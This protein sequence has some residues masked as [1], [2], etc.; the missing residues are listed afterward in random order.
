MNQLEVYICPLPFKPPSHLPPH[1]TP[2]GW[3][4]TPVWV[5]WDIQQIS[6]GYMDCIFILLVISFEVGFPGSSAGKESTWNTGDSGSIL[7]LGRSPGE[8]T[9]HSLQYSWASLMVQM[10][11]NLPAM[12]ETWVQ[13]LVGELRAWKPCNAAKQTRN[14]EIWYLWIYLQGSNGED[15][16]WGARKRGWDVWRE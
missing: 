11:K 3:Y 14:L 9:G 10:V 6:I 16:G 15:T 7:E 4:R 8:G 12:Q 1:L 13:S 5:P 2:L